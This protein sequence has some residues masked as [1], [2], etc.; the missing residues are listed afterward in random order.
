VE[1]HG[2]QAIMN[3]CPRMKLPRVY[4][5]VDG[6]LLGRRGT[7][8]LDAAEGLI[9]GGAKLIQLRWKEHFSRSVFGE[10]ST[11]A[12]LCR[13]VGAMLIV[14]DRVDMALLLDAGVHLGQEDLPPRETR[15]MMGPERV[16]GFSTHN[17]S[18]FVEGDREPVDYLVIGPVFGTSSKLNPD[19]VVGTT[20]LARLRTSTGKPVVAIGG[21][22][23][24]N[25]AQVWR[26]GADS[27]AVIGDM[28][29]EECTK[30]S[31][32]QRF[33]E[34]ATIAVHE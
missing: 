25:A 33:E 22:T 15:Q 13:S 4:P 3:L 16:I 19:P 18:Q 31:I 6:G 34:W 29:P 1:I 8:L 11:I 10:A 26:A 2:I 21:I 5:I 7:R 27:V 30:A 9:E 24:D 14:D 28:Y 12:K 32:R 23:R 17:E 20:E